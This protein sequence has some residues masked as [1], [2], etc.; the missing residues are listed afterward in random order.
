[1]LVRDFDYVLPPERIAQQPLEDRAASRLLVFDRATGGFEDNLFRNFPALL[2]PDDLLVINDTRVLPA[3]LFARR[4]GLHSQPVSP[5]NPSARE[6]LQGR[7]EVLLTAQHA[8]LEWSALVR[9]G[10]KLPVGER[11]HFFGAERPGGEENLTPLLSAEVVG[12]GEFGERRLRFAAVSDFY[13][14]LDRLGHMPLPPYIHRPDEGSDRERY[15]AVF[16]TERGSVAAPTAG[17]HFT[18][19]ILASIRARGVEVASL[20][21]HVGLGTF[22]PVR[23]ERLEDIHLHAERY[24]LPEKTAQAVNRALREGRRVIA[25]GTTTVRTLEHCA[26]TA[27]DGELRAHSGET[28]MFISPGYEFRV[29]RGLLTNFHL[30]QSTLLMLVCAFGGTEKVLAAYRHAVADQYRFFSYGDCMFL[31]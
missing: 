24:T 29:V 2:Q 28:Q 9:P 11:L 10:R 6:H 30:P 18:S 26:R 3:R 25:V 19:E 21:L 12:R 13:A 1:V 16:A 17:L 14:V 23:V 5:R 27:D 22:Q 15:Q 20:T 7:V 31:A 8:P 4:A